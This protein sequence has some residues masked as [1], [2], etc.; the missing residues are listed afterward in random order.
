MAPLDAATRRTLRARAHHLDPVVAIGQQGLSPAVLHEI[1]VALLAHELIKVRVFS[2]DRATRAALLVQLA[3]A[4][5]AAP[6]Q[7]LGKLF[8]LWRPNPELA[9]ARRPTGRARH[10]KRAPGIDDP[11]GKGADAARGKTGVRG[12]KAKTT[13]RKRG[14][15]AA[16]AAALARE[17]RRQPP[18]ERA[19][20]DA[21]ARPPARGRPRPAAKGA[22]PAVTPQAPRSRRDG[23]ARGKAAAPA[24]RTA[25]PAGVPRAV[26]PRRRRGRG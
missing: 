15:T 8:V 13:A 9:A 4:V 1:E 25:P 2:D 3:A 24:D 20:D 10:R 26:Q 12:M 11:R 6:V 22:A 14:S 21:S 18:G 19:S 17:R 16:H 7:H 5:D 23:A